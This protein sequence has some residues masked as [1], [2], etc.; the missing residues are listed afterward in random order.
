[1]LVLHQIKKQYGKN[2]V[3]REINLQAANG[4][5]VGILGGNG[6]GKTTLLSV[7]GGILRPDSGSFR[8]EGEEL[9]EN[10]KRRRTLVS[11]SPQ[12]NPLMEELSGFDNLLLWHDRATV[13]RGLAPDGV[14]TALGAADFLKK[15]VAK[16]SGGMKKR[17]SIAIAVLREPKILLLDEPT[18]ALDMEGKAQFYAYLKCFTA[19]GGTAL[20]VTHDFAE[21]AH[22]D[23]LVFL[24]DG[25]LRN[26]PQPES[27]AAA[28]ALFL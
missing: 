22:C 9:F 1:M 23:Q 8:Y 14:I 5:C 27:A 11:F 12:A 17:L 4:S 28:E 10:A 3:L 13:A 26:I 16:L 7:L 6:S 21:F 25:V 24:R 2:A 18:A 19:A 15:P 20:F